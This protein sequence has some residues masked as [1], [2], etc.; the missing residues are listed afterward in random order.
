MGVWGLF[1]CTISFFS[2][3]FF[4]RIFFQSIKNVLLSTK[5]IVCVCVDEMRRPTGCFLHKETSAPLQ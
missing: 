2:S 4:S 3:F 5:P 1:D